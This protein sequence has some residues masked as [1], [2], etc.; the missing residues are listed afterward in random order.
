[1]L[2]RHFPID[3]DKPHGPI[4]SHIDPLF[5]GSFGAARLDRIN[6]LQQADPDNTN[7]SDIAP[8]ILIE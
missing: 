1:M 8:K 7:L 5:V 4:Y 3:L 6:V 2:N